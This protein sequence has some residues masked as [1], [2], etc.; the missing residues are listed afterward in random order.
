MAVAYA[1]PSSKTLLRQAGNGRLYQLQSTVGTLPLLHL[2][3]SRDDIGRQYGQLLGDKI[4]ASASRT[5]GLLSSSVSSPDLAACVLDDAWR[6]LQ[7]HTPARYLAEIDAIVAGARATGVNLSNLEIERLTAISNFD[8]YKREQ[9]LA[10]FVDAE[11]LEAFARLRPMSCTMFAVWGSRTIDGKLYALRNLDWVSQTG[12]H[13]DR[14]ITLYEPDDGPAYV[15]I[16]YA[17]VI[18]ALAGMNEEGIT[19]SEVGA[20][21]VHEELDGTPW[22]LMARRVLESSR[23]LQDAIAIVQDT[24]HTLGYNYLIGFGDPRH[25]GADAFNPCAAALET[26]YSCCELFVD[27]DPKEHAAQWVSPNGEIVR[28]GLPLKDA[29]FRADTAFAAN[30]RALQATDNGPGDPANDGDPRK[31]DSYIACHIPMHDMIKAY[32]TGSEY[33]F[34]VR[35]IKVIDAGPPRKIGH[36]EALAIAAT[37]AHNVEKLAVNDWNVISVVYAPTDLEF[38]AAYESCDDSGTWKN[39]PDSGYWHLNLRELLGK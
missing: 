5:I 19:L 7:Q 22:T 28:Y 23:T 9:R 11:V 38:W 1:K 33:V 36:G 10:E 25:F 31:G 14:L 17:G 24:R 21:S 16:G 34:P 3:G 39:A 4:L 32:E 15:T 27:D 26:N 20:F 2:R 37:V 6:M 13:H 8:L 18:G 29:V 30:T 12:A 35:N